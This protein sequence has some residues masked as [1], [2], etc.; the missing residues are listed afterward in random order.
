MKKTKA[1]LLA[2]AIVVP[3]YGA[4]SYVLYCLDILD[5]NGAISVFIAMATTEPLVAWFRKCNK[6]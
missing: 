6:E 2:W 1:Y 5:K 4:T 3:I